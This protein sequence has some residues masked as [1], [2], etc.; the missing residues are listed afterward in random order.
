MSMSQICTR[1][2]RPFEDPVPSVTNNEGA[3]YDIATI[4]CC[5]DCN[6]II[7]IYIYRFSSAY[8]DRKARDPLKIYKEGG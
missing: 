2:N 3:H 5:A 6:R 8:F 7:M 4:E 1:C